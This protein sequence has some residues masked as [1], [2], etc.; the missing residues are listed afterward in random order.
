[1]GTPYSFA[2]SAEGALKWSLGGSLPQGLNLDPATGEISGTPEEAGTFS[3]TVKVENDHGFDA[4]EFTISIAAAPAAPPIY[5]YPPYIAP[6]PLA[7]PAPVLAPITV[8]IENKALY[9]A[10][11]LNRVGLF[12]GTGSDPLG[13]PIY[14]LDRNLTRI[15][16]LVLIIRLLGTE[17]EALAFKGA[18]PF[19]DVPDW[20]QKYASYAFSSGITVGVNSEHT[21]LDASRQVTYKEFTAFLLR[22]LHYFEAQGDFEFDSALEKALEVQLYSAIADYEATGFLRGHAAEAM[23]KALVTPLKDSSADLLASLVERGAIGKK[24]AVEVDQYARKIK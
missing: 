24:E 9:S 10:E 3:F 18:N 12:A 20:A 23:V 4:K 13:N 2:V 5:Y 11:V 17:N 14:S 6:M 16:A 21:L 22:A 1:V 7:S 8:P 19:K 15:D